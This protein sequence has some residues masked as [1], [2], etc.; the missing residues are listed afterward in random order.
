M[1]GW[2]TFK[3]KLKKTVKKSS[4]P[5]FVVLMLTLMALTGTA[6]AENET[7]SVNWTEIGDLISGVGNIMPSIGNL[8]VAIVPVILILIVVGFVVGIFDSIISAIRDAFRF[9]R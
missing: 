3:A 9:L 1:K 8:V 6:A 2:R 5:V 4:A 7:L